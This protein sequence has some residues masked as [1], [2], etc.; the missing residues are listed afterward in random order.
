MSIT[1]MRSEVK[2]LYPNATWSGKVDKMKD[3]QVMAIYF[4]QVMKRR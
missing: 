4:S 2:K 3:N 1:I